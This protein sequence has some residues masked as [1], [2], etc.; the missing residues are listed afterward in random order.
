VR[1]SGVE[2][3]PVPYDLISTYVDTIERVCS[4]IRPAAASFAKG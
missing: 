1:S 3:M 2:Y 4:H